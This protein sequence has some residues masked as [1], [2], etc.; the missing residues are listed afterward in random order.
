MS[1]DEAEAPTASDAPAASAGATGRA[2][3]GLAGQAGATGGGGPAGG[4]AGA[5][6]CTPPACAG[7]AAGA[8]GAGAGAG[9]AAGGGAGGAGA[10]GFE[11][12]EDRPGGDVT[13]DRHDEL[14][15]SQ[16]APALSLEQRGLFQ[17]GKA[18]FEVPWV[19][20]PGPLPDRDG[21][22]PL[23]NATSCV[24]CHAR[25]G[26]GE[27]P[28]P[29]EPALALLLR[30]S[31]PLAGGG[32]GPEP[33]YGDQV[34]TAATS[35]VPA[36][37]RVTLAYDELPGAFGD[38]ETFSLR[39]PRFFIENTNYGPL[40]PDLLTSPRLAQP[41]VGLGLLAAIDEAAI[42]LAADP[43]D[44]D[45][46][47]ASGRVN[48]VPAGASAAATGRFGWKA[49]QP[50]LGAQNAG[51]LAGD[52]G[53]TTPELPS[54]TCTAAQTA[55]L[56]APQ[57]GSPEIGP[58]V[59]AALNF[60]TATLA[61]PSRPG[62]RDPDVLAGKAV[63]HGLG[64]AACHRPS[65]TTG[66]SPGL[67]EL[68]GQRIWPYSDLLLHDLGEGLADGRPDHEASGR[69]WRT[70]PLWGIGLTALVSGGA[71]FLHDGR[72]RSIA[73]AVLWHGGEAEASREAFRA[74]SADDRR[75][76]VRFVE[77]L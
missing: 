7:G 73:E 31:V 26:R 45:G 46:D 68:A 9:G 77:S 32:A 27:P 22:G 47:G 67:P 58:T 64:C 65:W 17:T 38:G 10:G 25:N 36:E 75:L 21:L 57:G 62:A 54:P 70:P 69:E 23:F 8:G 2:G 42:A 72:A 44:A 11:E 16:P 40:P 41:L 30:L 13:V 71:A 61:V 59:L 34:Q 37:G 56:A 53:L 5:D 28:A 39:R 50:D 74:A 33:T 6:G 14:A 1:C 52:M 3:A 51:A 43:D 20:A 12:G 55:C 60:Y 63:F 48:R 49:N 19:A 76:L 15:F 4:A 18:I 29:G 35:G 66:A 24:A